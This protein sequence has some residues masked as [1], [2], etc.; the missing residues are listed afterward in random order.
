MPINNNNEYDLEKEEVAEEL[1]IAAIGSHKISQ[2]FNQVDGQENDKMDNQKDNRAD[3]QEDSKVDSQEDDDQQ[4]DYESES[5]LIEGLLQWKQRLQETTQRVQC[6]ID[7]AKILKSDKVKYTSV[8]YYIQLLQHKMPKIEASII[9]AKIHNGGEYRA[10]CIQAW[11]KTCLENKLLPPSQR[12]KHPSKSL[13]YDEYV[14]IR[15]ANYLRAT[16]FQVNSRLIKQFFENQILSELYIDQAQTI[17]LST[18][19]LFR[20]KFLQEM[21]KYEKLMSKWNDI[22][23]KVCEELYLL[24]NEQKHI[25]IT[26]DKCT[27]HSYN[28]IRK[29]WAPEEEQPLRKKG[30]GQGLH[31]SEFLTETIG[32]LKD[33]EG[34][35]KVIMQFGANNNGYWDG[36]KLLLLLK[37]VITIFER[38]YP[39]CIGVWAFDNATSHTGM[40]PDALVA[41]R[42]NLNSDDMQPEMRDMT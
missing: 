17:S 5:D 37:N 3:S 41:A 7:K 13:L 30:L 24:H 38:T 26:Y 22:N 19:Q 34:E 42:M 8:I 29:F 40:A 15:I 2:F 6:I 27:F 21:E 18:A 36:K 14:T 25:L 39:G 9:V 4:L 1:K 33:R 31:V 16:K 28:G 20:Q 10:K 23:C 35:A 12:E 11:T 32:R